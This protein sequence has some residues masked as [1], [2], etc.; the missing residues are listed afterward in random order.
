MNILREK[1]RCTPMGARLYKGSKSS[2]TNSADTTIFS[3]VEDARVTAGTVGLSQSSGNTLQV[4]SSDAVQA[5]ASMG[6]ETIA[7]AGEAVVQLNQSSQ[8]ANVTAW[9][10]TVT[11]GAELVD[12]LIDATNKQNT[13]SRKTTEKLIDATTKQLEFGQ[14]SA[15]QI[16]EKGAALGQA[17]ISSFQP[18]DNKA[19]DTSL[20]LGMIAAAAVAA[21]LLL[22]KQ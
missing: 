20:K 2:S 14:K 17:A 9:D 4:N 21:T 7:R 1:L 3:T 10:T 15:D 8:A 18:T 12:R 13:S 5:M 6:A 19:Q 22:R 16:A 11:R